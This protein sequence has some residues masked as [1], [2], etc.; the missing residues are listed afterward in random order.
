MKILLLLLFSMNLFAQDLNLPEPERRSNW[1][2]AGYGLVLSASFVDGVRTGWIHDGRRSFERKW[3]VDPYGFWGTE[4]WRMI[5]IDG[6]PAKGAKSWLHYN[7]GARD[8]E[9]VS[10]RFY[11]TAYIT[12]G[13][14]IGFNMDLKKRDVIELVGLMVAS[15]LA[16]RA[17]MRWVRGK[18]FF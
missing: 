6:D 12:G 10:D 7:I 15:S 13:V 17:G 11:K 14:V 5:Y 16:K 18:P 8:F 1:R 9:H 3:N 4:S 2:Y